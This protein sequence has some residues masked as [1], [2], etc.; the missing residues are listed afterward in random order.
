M[1]F[2]ISRSLI[3]FGD[4]Y[5]PPMRAAELTRASAPM[6]HGPKGPTFDIGRYS[7]W[8]CHS[9]EYFPLLIPVL[10]YHVNEPFEYL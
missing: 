2:M 8:E 10:G 5:Y 3:A 4:S 6:L 7:G 1:G 9:A